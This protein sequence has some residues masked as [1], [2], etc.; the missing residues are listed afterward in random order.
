MEKQ[1]KTLNELE[2]AIDDSE[3]EEVKNINPNFYESSI[4]QDGRHLLC[5]LPTNLIE[6]LNILEDIEDINGEKVNKKL[7]DRLKKNWKIVF[8]E[9][10]FENREGKFKIIEK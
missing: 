1:F 5:R 6:S 7:K 4:S 8:E 10:D 2:K 9:I 3:N